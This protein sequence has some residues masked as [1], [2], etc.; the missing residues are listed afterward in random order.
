[1]NPNPSADRGHVYYRYE[2]PDGRVVLV[3][4]LAKLPVDVRDKAQRMDHG[5]TATPGTLHDVLTNSTRNPL[6]TSPSV[7]SPALGFGSLHL[8]SFAVGVLGGLG[9]A[10]VV[11][12]L[13][14]SSSSSFLKRVLVMLC[15]TTVMGLVLS[16]LYLGWLRKSAGLGDNLLAT[17]TEL[18]DDAK[19]TMERVK[20]QRRQQQE[21]LDALEHVH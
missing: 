13:A 16:S 3:D 17:P 4:D 2:S 8:P 9:M 19:R 18:V 1:M 10:M 21:Q 6:T 11:A 5:A 14:K 12:W 20:E 7:E 15:L